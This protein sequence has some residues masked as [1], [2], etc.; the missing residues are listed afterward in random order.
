LVYKPAVKQKTKVAAP[1]LR[2]TLTKKKHSLVFRSIK[3]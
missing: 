2:H 3:M 1:S